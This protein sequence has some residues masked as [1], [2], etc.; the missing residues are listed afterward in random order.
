VDC[1]PPIY[2]SH[3]SWHDRHVPPYFFR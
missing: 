3:H 1:D 2:A